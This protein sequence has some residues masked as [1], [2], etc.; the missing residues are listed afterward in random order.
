MDISRKGWGVTFASMIALTVGSPVISV[1]TVGVFMK[2]MLAEFGWSRGDYFAAFTVG[3]L[4]GSLGMLLAGVASDKFG[5]RNSLLVGIT[6]YALTGICFGL[7]GP[8][9]AEYMVLWLIVGLLAMSTSAL[10]Y[11]KIVSGWMDSKR[12]L[13]IAI[14]MVGMGIGNMLIPP[15]TAS[16]LIPHYGWREARVILGVLSFVV[17]FPLVFFFVREPHE[18]A[19]TH[20]AHAPQTGEP[21]V[22]ALRSW[23]FWV[24]GLSFLLSGGAIAAFQFNVLPILTDN[25]F[26]P[27]IAALCLSVLA[28]GQI[29]GRFGCGFMLDKFQNPK[30]VL[31]WLGFGAGGIALLP[32]AGSLPVAIMAV[33][34]LG[35][36][37]AAEQQITAYFMS[38][39]YGVKNLG[40]IYG[41]ISAIYLFGIS[42][43]PFIASR[44]YDRFH[45][46]KVAAMVC[47]AMMVAAALLLLVLPAY[48]FKR[49][50]ADARQIAEPA[51]KAA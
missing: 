3:G 29:V 30:S 15:L 37:Y 34:L 33:L 19:Q 7:I 21:L 27:A 14:V 20:V 45:D 13:A 17:A 48:V 24:V 12:G 23:I 11:V 50:G 44:L 43:G 6:L 35:F 4:V 8:T 16:Y 1:G 51:A 40:S 25:G 18:A 31:L 36:S 28:A 38:R 49:P 46:Y 41:A 2:P 42:S 9:W 47:E 10:I 32:Q 39:Y 22:V 26:D 5:G